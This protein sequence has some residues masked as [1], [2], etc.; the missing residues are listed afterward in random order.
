MTN[1]LAMAV[2]AE[3]KG[4]WLREAIEGQG[5]SLRDCAKKLGLSY[6]TTVYNHANDVSYMGA[7]LLAGLA[8]IYPA[9]NLHY[10]LTGIGRPTLGTTTD[11]VPTVYISRSGDVNIRIEE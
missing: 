1:E 10:I 2:D 3:I 11:D 9:I 7:K 8:S 5:D 4:E 6:P